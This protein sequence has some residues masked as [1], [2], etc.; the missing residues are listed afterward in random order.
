MRRIFCLT[1]F[2]LLSMPAALPAQKPADSLPAYPPPAEVKA[3]FLKMLDRPKVDPAPRQISPPHT[4]GGIVT[5]H[6][7][8]ATEKKA[9]GSIERV[10]MLILR[11]EKA[12]G[13]LPAVIVLHG[14]GG[15]KEG[16][17]GICIELANRGIIGVAIDS[18]Y[19]GERIPGGAHG[20]KEYV[21]A[22]T[23]AWRAK[24]GEPQEHPFYYD[25][26]WDLW[27]VVDYLDTRSRR[28][29]QAIGDDRHQHGRDRN[30][31]GRLG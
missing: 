25:T 9:D 3:A 8:I 6:L 16:V 29:S 26:C 27:R 30:L 23:R 15:N 11:P 22:I 13:R 19:H 18:R 12:V 5:E 28:R 4:F 31:A 14:T 21:A 20:N 1:L 17:R 10:P 24:P 2:C 7:S